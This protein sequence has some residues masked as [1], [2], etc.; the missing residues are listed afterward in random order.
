MTYNEIKWIMKVFKLLYTF[1]MEKQIYGEGRTS[2]IHK[3][4][5]HQNL[6]Y[7]DQEYYLCLMFMADFE[8]T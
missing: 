4:I 7:A 8:G 2:H 5:L 6:A 3:F 1:P